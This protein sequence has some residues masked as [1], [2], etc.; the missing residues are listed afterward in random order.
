MINNFADL[1]LLF[2]GD[3]V[4]LP[5]EEKEIWSLLEVGDREGCEAWREANQWE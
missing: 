2:C 4:R 1:A 5:C 3:R